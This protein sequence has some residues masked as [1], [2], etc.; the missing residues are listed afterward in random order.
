MFTPSSAPFLLAAELIERGAQESWLL[1]ENPGEGTPRCRLVES[2]FVHSGRQNARVCVGAAHCQRR[3]RRRLVGVGAGLRRH[4][5]GWLLFIRVSGVHVVPLACIICARHWV[6]CSTA[7]HLSKP[8]TPAAAQAWHLL[9]LS[10]RQYCEWLVSFR[11][12]LSLR[13]WYM[14]VG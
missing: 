7:G 13:P 4:T 11:R 9:L 6:L 3:R 12:P 1:C 2:G 14:E 8:R 10:Q 5:R